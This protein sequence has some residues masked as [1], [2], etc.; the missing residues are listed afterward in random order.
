MKWHSSRIIVAV[1]LLSLSATIAGG[2]R[3]EAPVA[4]K[5]ERASCAVTYA[6]EPD[7][8][9]ALAITSQPPGT[10]AVCMA[11]ECSVSC[12]LG[13]CQIES[14]PAFAKCVCRAGGHPMCGCV[15]FCS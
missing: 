12:P 14:C 2:I 9:T 15:D 1:F 11:E 13:S 5:P 10:N 6:V 8:S 7:T 4:A 3:S